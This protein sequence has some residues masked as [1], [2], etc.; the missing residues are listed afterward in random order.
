MKYLSFLLPAMLMFS[1][2]VF[3]QQEQEPWSKN[4]LMEPDILASRI[5][6]GG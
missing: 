5:K 4:Q 3:T 6:C 1:K 2:G